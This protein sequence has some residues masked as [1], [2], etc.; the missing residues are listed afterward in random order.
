[1]SCCKTNTMS[2]M[3][4]TA[5]SENTESMS[6]GTGG[7]VCGAGGC[8]TG[9]CGSG[10]CGSKENPY[11]FTRMDL[12]EEHKSFLQEKSVKEIVE[13]S[14]DIWQRGDCGV[15]V[16]VLEYCIAQ[17]DFATISNEYK[18]QAYYNLCIGLT[19]IQENAQ[20]LNHI[21]SAI[22]CMQET[23]NTALLSDLY[24]VYSQCCL[25]SGDSASSFEHA[26]TAVNYATDCQDY[27]RCVTF[28]VYYATILESK[29]KIKEAYT[30][31]QNA[32]SVANTNSANIDPSVWAEINAEYASWNTK[33]TAKTQEIE[34]FVSSGA[35]NSFSQNPT[36]I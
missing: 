24:L 34:Q 31:I 3:E 9:G 1:M 20:V 11:A 18:T 7:C 15:A 26:K 27:N 17:P 35:T 28:Q 25:V 12:T 5:I 10:G 30:Q 21:Q 6:C 14:F 16:P 32:W 29:Q 4:N 8:G 22:S 13:M 33:I 2:A 23:G 19:V 36:S